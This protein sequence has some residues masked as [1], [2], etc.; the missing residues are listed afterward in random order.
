MAEDLKTQFVCTFASKD[1]SALRKTADQGAVINM[2]THTTTNVKSSTIIG[3][4]VKLCARYGL[5]ECSF[6]I[7]NSMDDNGLVVVDRTET[8]CGNP[9]G[10]DDLE[11]WEREAVQLYDA[12]Y[13]FRIE[14]QSL[15]VVTNQELRNAG[16]IT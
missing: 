11:Q 7:P 12:T 15:S 1:V 4:L 2:W 10:P 3:L 5:D 16:V 13:R 6:R 14:R 9:A 8:E